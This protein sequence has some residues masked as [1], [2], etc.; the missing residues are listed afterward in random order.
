MNDSIAVE[1][2]RLRENYEKGTTCACCNQFVKLYRRKLT[3]SQM[4]GLIKLYRLHMEEPAYYHYTLLGPLHVAADFA[5]LKLFG[6]IKPGENLDSTKK[7]AGTWII[8]S[9]GVQFVLCR[10]KIPEAVFIYNQKPY[11][12]SE[13]LIN[14]KE[15]IKNKFDYDELMNG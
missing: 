4:R 6:L 2:Q 5:K 3:S 15:A 10:I 7:A 13:N 14:I 12:F 1:K 11:R 8:T 9:K